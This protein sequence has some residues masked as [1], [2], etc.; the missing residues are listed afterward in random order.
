MDGMIGTPLY[1]RESMM[2]DDS[3]SQGGSEDPE[4]GLATREILDRWLGKESMTLWDAAS[5][6]TRGESRR[7][8]PGPV[9]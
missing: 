3:I 8:G 2:N 4:V 9:R 5:D 1:S 7:A 6:C